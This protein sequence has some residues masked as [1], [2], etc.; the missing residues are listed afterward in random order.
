MGA[1]GEQH[2]ILRLLCSSGAAKKEKKSHVR[3]LLRIIMST[4]LGGFATA[5][6]GAQREKSMQ[7]LS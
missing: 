1:K 6:E 5:F 4:S 2:F 3:L 7:I